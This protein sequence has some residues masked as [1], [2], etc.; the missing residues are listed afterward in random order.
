[1]KFGPQ[2]GHFPKPK[3]SYN[4]CK[5]EDKD[6]ARQAFESFGLYINYTRGQGYLGGF[7]GSAEKKEE[8]PAWDGGE[9]GG[10]GGNPQYC[11]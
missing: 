9:V 7:I 1:M 2:Y 6:T 5:V 11:C 10:C 8:W 3:K 4:I